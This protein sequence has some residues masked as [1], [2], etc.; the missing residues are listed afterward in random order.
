MGIVRVEDAV[1]PTST[2]RMAG[3]PAVGDDVMS[4]I[5]AG[6]RKIARIRDE[7]VAASATNIGEVTIVGDGIMSTTTAHG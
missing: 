5:T 3:E 4:T 6:A 2:V 1:E 7:V